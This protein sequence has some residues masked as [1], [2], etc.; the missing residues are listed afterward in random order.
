MERQAGKATL[1]GR[2]WGG[3][4]AG[5]VI[6]IGGSWLGEVVGGALAIGEL[7]GLGPA[8]WLGGLIGLGSATLFALVGGAVASRWAAVGRGPGVI[9]GLVVWGTAATFGSFA[10]ALLGG[11]ISLIAGGTPDAAQVS[12]GFT[13]LGLIAMMGA[14]ILG[15]AAG[16]VR[17]ERPG[18]PAG[19]LRRPATPFR[20]RR[21][22]EARTSTVQGA[23]KWT[24]PATPPARD[25]EIPPP[26]VH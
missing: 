22:A 15:G 7:E 12:L 18:A 3:V 26:S 16:A 11:S 17:E 1:D 23:E 13:S 21:S 2:L 4:L 14:A 8:S 5:A 20:L 10:F 9:L 6:A 25:D 24:P 19:Q